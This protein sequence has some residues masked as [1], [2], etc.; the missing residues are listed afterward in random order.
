MFT[1]LSRYEFTILD[2]EKRKQNKVKSQYTEFR[3]NKYILV[4][5]KGTYKNF[6]Y[7]Y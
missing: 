2:S 4:T 7:M 1:L 6:F 5:L 3:V